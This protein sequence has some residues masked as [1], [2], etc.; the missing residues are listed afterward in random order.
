MGPRTRFDPI[1]IKDNVATTVSMLEDL[2]R[3]KPNLQTKFDVCIVGAGP[4]GITIARELSETGWSILLAESG[5]LI[6]SKQTQDLN[7][8]ASVGHPARMHE[9]RHRVFGGSATKWGGRCA[10]LDPIDFEQRQW[11]NNSGWP[12]SFDSLL[13]YYERAKVVSNFLEPWV[14]DSKALA[15]LKVDLPLLSCQGLKPH[16]WRVAQPYPRASWRTRWL[17]RRLRAFDWGDAYG[18]E[19]FGKENVHV[20]LNASLVDLRSDEEGSR[21][22]SI[23]LSSLNGNSLT[24]EANVFV[25]CCSGI[26][27]ARILLNAPASM[28]EKVNFK[29]NVGRFLTQH[30]RGTIGWIKTN[31]RN[32]MHLQRMFNVFQ[33][34]PRVKVEYEV[35]F[36]LTEG[37]QREHNL[38]NASVV[39]VYEPGKLSSWAA[40]KRLIHSARQRQ[41]GLQNLLDL[42]RVI[43]KFPF[44]NL[45]RR[46]LLGREIYHRDPN[47]R[48]VIDLEQEP[49][50]DSR[51]FLSDEQDALGVRR[52]V[53]DWR[54]S[55][56][57]RRT[58]AFFGKALKKEFQSLGLGDIELAG[59]LMNDEMLTDAHLDGNFHYIG[60][61]RMSRSEGDGVVDENAKV[62]G[63]DNLYVAGASIFPTGGHANPTLTIVALAIRLADHLRNDK[64][65][66]ARQLS[67]ASFSAGMDIS[68]TPAPG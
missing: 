46:F 57:E 47:I 36:A 7:V 11:V 3:P 41:L 34:P 16:V 37:A 42:V 62:H 55:D 39:L 68:P 66:A 30:P 19:L 17:P 43:T 56:I 45:G 60:T 10:M 53:V 61:T 15:E 64:S 21:V 6:E 58:A 65:L 31:T 40:F 25:L 20:L 8:G 54:I 32:A 26:E 18:R 2:E 67:N 38:V 50:R 29:D 49:I 9:G 23:V 51:I 12:F 5:G 24:I 48:V 1:G 4:A 63:I 28:M 13:P 44:V 27:N 35:G 14:E 22:Q 33:R 52:A 59:W